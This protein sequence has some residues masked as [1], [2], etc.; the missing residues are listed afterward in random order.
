MDFI[1]KKYTILMANEPLTLWIKNGTIQNAKF[2]DKKISLT[3]DAEAI[4]LIKDNPTRTVNGNNLTDNLAFTHA[5][6]KMMSSK[7][8]LAIAKNDKKTLSRFARSEL[9]PDNMKL[10]FIAAINRQ[11]GL[12]GILTRAVNR[13]NAIFQ[14]LAKRID[15]YFEKIKENVSNKKLDKYLTEFQ[16]TEFNKAPPL[17]DI[18]L[19]QHVN[20][21]LAELAEEFVKK[22]GIKELGDEKISDKMLQN[23]FMAQAVRAELDPIEAKTALFKEVF[24]SQSKEQ[25]AKTEEKVLA[26]TSQISDM[27]AVI[28]S[29]QSRLDVYEKKEASKNETLEDFVTLSKSIPAVEAIGILIENKEYLG[30][31]EAQKLEFENQHL[32]NMEP[33]QERA[34]EAKEIAKELDKKPKTTVETVYERNATLNF[35][36]SKTKQ[37]VNSKWQ[38]LQ[39]INREQQAQNR[40]FMNISAVKFN[41][42]SKNSLDSWKQSAEANGVSKE[43]TDK[44]VDASL[45]NAKSLVG[46]GIMQE[47]SQGEFKFVDNFSKEAL[48]KNID[49]PV[50]QIAEANKG[51]SVQVEQNPKAE[52][53]E[54]VADISSEKSFEKLLDSNGQI[55]SQ[56]L[57]AFADHLS[58]LATQL[59]QQE[60]VNKNAVTR[61]D[62]SIANQ[63][64]TQTQG[65][66]NAR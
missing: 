60:Q 13:T 47:V 5:V 3:L 49:K 9:V 43:L 52:L 39:K 22:N 66:E 12:R 8:E 41:G 11:N 45:R 6:S 46:A 31:N 56:K 34:V 55:D 32:Y 50:A 2:M 30:L 14:N 44:F 25:R 20:P 28:S 53:Q 37:E 51:V 42:V 36:E 15:R 26:Q 10:D 16:L 17:R 35:Y 4:R 62:I 29:L 21:K 57:H 48:Y 65:V 38:E 58:N 54:R 64:Q 40:D 24:Q 63:T 27:Q 1:A 19:A 23:D 18:N 33:L 59:H 61:D 7:L